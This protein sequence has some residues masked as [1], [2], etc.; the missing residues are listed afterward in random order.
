MVAAL[1]LLLLDAALDVA[2]QLC[3]VIGDLVEVGVPDDVL[4]GGQGAV[5]S[6][7]LD[8]D[9]VLGQFL[10]SPSLFFVLLQ[11]VV[12]PLTSELEALYQHLGSIEEPLVP[13]F[14]WQV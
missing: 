8:L 11:D 14:V 9:C 6:Y 10:P 2:V 12:V 1:A 7:A 4:Q 5:L 3:N 13:V